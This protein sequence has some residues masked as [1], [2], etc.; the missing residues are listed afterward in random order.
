MVPHQAQTKGNLMPAAGSPLLGTI[1]PIE[2]TGFYNMY[3]H[4]ALGQPSYRRISPLHM[5]D[6]GIPRL[7]VLTLNH[8]WENTR[9]SRLFV[10][11]YNN[12]PN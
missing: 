7:F 4:C 8:V 12:N 10:W 11:I 1:V 5:Y 3:G 9:V 2:W 6:P